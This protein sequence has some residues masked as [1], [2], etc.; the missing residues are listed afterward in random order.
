M[1]PRGKALARRHLICASC[2]S[3]IQFDSSGCTN[4]WAEMRGGAC[5]FT[6]K[7]CTEVTRLVGEVGDLRQMM[8]SM[9]RMI[10]RQGLEEERGITG[11]QVA[12]LEET[13][14]KEKCERVMTPGNSS[15]EESRNGK[16]TAE[17]SSS[18]DMGTLIEI[19]GEHGTDGEGTD[20]QLLGGKGIRPGTQMLATHRYKKNPDGPVG[21][22]LDLSEGET[23]VYL[24]KHDD[25]DHWWLAENGKGQVGYVPAA[26]LMIILDETLQ[27]E[28]SDTRKEGQGK[29]TDGTKIGGRW[30]SM[31]KEERRTQ[32]Q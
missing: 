14:E 13:E 21:N 18:E 27:E 30:D 1:A 3:W 17:R 10:T 7:G 32:Q 28:D 6:C 25:N 12:R 20:R 29:G 4:S 19:E 31:E 16:E 11:I 24:V 8:E 15:T 5:V 2:S 9:K 26:Y 22:E 23:L